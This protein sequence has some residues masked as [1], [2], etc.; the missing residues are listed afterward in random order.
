MRLT[1]PKEHPPAYLHF[2]F[3]IWKELDLTKIWICSNTN[4]LSRSTLWWLR[5]LPKKLSSIEKGEV[6]DGFSQ[7]GYTPVCGPMRPSSTA[8]PVLLGMREAA[9]QDMMAGYSWVFSTASEDAG[10]HPLCAP[11]QHPELLCELHLKTSRQ[12]NSE[13][14]HVSPPGEVLAVR[15]MV[16][17]LHR[18]NRCLILPLFEKN[19]SLHPLLCHNPLFLQQHELVAQIVSWKKCCLLR[20]HSPSIRAKWIQDGNGCF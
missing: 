1:Q 16:H 4:P 18:E 13:C 9:M 6:T 7:K 12:K 19:R 15:K 10:C 3:M 8:C 14:Q 20:W 2:Q 5:S 17:V 11:E